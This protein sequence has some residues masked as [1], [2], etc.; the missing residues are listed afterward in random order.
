MDTTRIRVRIGTSIQE[1]SMSKQ[2]GYWFS[3]ALIALIGFMASEARAASLTLTIV[4]NGHTI[5]I[6]S[7]GGPFT[8]PGSSATSLQVNVSALNTTLMGDGSKVTFSSLGASSDFPGAANPAGGTLSQSGLAKIDVGATG[9]ST[10][11]TITASLSGYTAPSGS[12]GTM[13]DTNT[14]NFTNTKLGDSQSSWSKWNGTVMGP[15]TTFTSTGPGLN[16]YS[17]MDATPIPVFVTPYSLTNFAS[18]SLTPNASAVANDQY[19][20]STLVNATAVP[21]PTSVV[22]M[23]MSM[24]LPLVV[25]GLLRRRRRAV[26]K[27]T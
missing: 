20:V 3:L 22:L 14:A 10:S 9:V 15:T 6:S 19:T 27:L 11:L 1:V 13:T 2:R 17:N 4:A 18:I 26:A 25:L 8:L 21:E 16:S 23:L 12:V 24:P 5:V 7:A